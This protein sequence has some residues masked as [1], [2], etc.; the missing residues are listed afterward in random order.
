MTIDDGQHLC[1]FDSFQT[2]RQTDRQTN[3]QR[4]T[5]TTF[6]L[7]YSLINMQMIN[8]VVFVVFGCS[9]NRSCHYSPM[10]PTIPNSSRMFNT[11]EPWHSPAE[12]TNMMLVSMMIHTRNTQRTQ[13]MQPMQ[14][15]KSHA[16]TN[17][18]KTKNTI[19]ANMNIEEFLVFNVHLVDTNTRPSL[20]SHEIITHLFHIR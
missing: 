14:P 12:G 11:T 19:S 17:L 2:D 18:D 5:S 16:A 7:L 8:A 4:E 3:K 13:P 10:Q 15:C 20:N 9:F 6:L 1:R